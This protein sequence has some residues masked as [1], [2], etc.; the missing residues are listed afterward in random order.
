MIFKKNLKYISFALSVC[1]LLTNFAF[2]DSFDEVK[3]QY[4][5]NLPLS[6]NVNY[7]KN[8]VSGYKSGIVNTYIIEIGTD[9]LEN[10]SF[11]SPQYIHSRKSI[12]N[13]IN[14]D[15][16]DGYKAIGAINA[17]FF[18]MSTGVP[19]SAFIKDGIIYTS[20]RDSF[21]LAKDEENKFFFDKPSIKITMD[22]KDTVYYI[23]HLNKEFSDKGVFMY[24]DVF[25]DNTKIKTP[26]NEIILLPYED[27]IHEFDMAQM[28]FGEENI[29]SDLNV[30]KYEYINSGYLEE[31]EN[32]SDASLIRM[33]ITIN[34]KYVQSLDEFAKD[35][36][37]TKIRHEYYKLISVQPKINSS[38]DCVV[39]H[40]RV[41]GKNTSLEIPENSILLVADNKTYG[42]TLGNFAIGENVTIN[43]SGN[44]KFNNVTHAIGTGC[45]I[46][47]NGEILENTDLSHYKYANPRSAVGIREDGSIVLFGVDGRDMGNSKGL[48]LLE[49]ACE[50]KRLGC[51]YAANL[52][53]GGSTTVKINAPF[54]ENI[55]TV[56]MPSDSSERPVSNIIYVKDDI[57][58]TTDAV[59]SFFDTYA[60][61]VLPSSS[62]EF[63]KPLYSDKNYNFVDAENVDESLFTYKTSNGGK[64]ENKV[65]YPE[66]NTGEFDIIS[67]SHDEFSNIAAKVVVPENVDKLEFLVDKDV[68]YVGESLEISV[69]SEFCGYEVVSSLK[70][71][72]IT[73]DENF[74]QFDENGVLVALAPCD[75]LEIS[76]QYGDKTESKVI[77]I[78]EI[79]FLDVY[80]HWSF[81]NISRLFDEKVVI[82]E[83]TDEGAKFFPDR[84][85]TKNEFCVMLSRILGLE[86]SET[87]ERGATSFF[88]DQNIPEWAYNAVA[89]L[90]ELELL[91]DFGV[92]DENG[93]YIFD[94][95][96]QVSRNDVMKVVGKICTNAPE[97]FQLEFSDVNQENENLNNIL[98][99]VYAG[100]FEGYEDN[101]LRARN[102]LTRGEGAAVFCRI[103]DYL[104]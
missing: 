5:T 44:E 40:T 104:K 33:V 11:A 89:S 77:K 8:L 96:S 87:F 16:E 32:V 42:Y 79:P 15:L 62:I 97:D 61:F 78:K 86:Q 55:K 93:N 21:C 52:D 7:S 69:K 91:S 4:Q 9:A 98:N 12:S 47:N 14:S 34:D 76:V 75:E 3:T 58:E 83:T 90:F 31:N 85:Y 19:E 43:I 10:I 49:L 53:G 99:C 95:Q 103:S 46:V 68:L 81:N 1:I 94:G 63:E 30:R 64:F 50:M 80:E 18:N 23:Q 84:A 27:K 92:Y 57:T 17:D 48:T 13:I 70:D 6:Q 59:Y 24:T 102:K 67:V 37:Y 74:A 73:F 26:S 35:L 38:I 20:D 56:N 2:A 101:T 54:F 82:G 51:V 65:F 22:A 72:K 29:P 100:I 36:G 88:N 45:M 25:S 60:K 66:G 41:D 39:S 71:Y 28:M